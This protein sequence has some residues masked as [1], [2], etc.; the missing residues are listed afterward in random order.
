METTRII[1]V[2]RHAK[3]SIDRDKM[4][5]IMRESYRK[6]SGLEP[7]PITV[8]ETKNYTILTMR[9]QRPKKRREQGR[10]TPITEFP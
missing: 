2:P 9:S 4:L 7:P 3:M 8:K 6:Q 5:S 10:A 1:R